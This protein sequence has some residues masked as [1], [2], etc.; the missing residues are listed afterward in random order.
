MVELALISV[1]ATQM[2]NKMQINQ[3]QERKRSQETMVIA[4]RNQ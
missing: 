1:H 2:K 4:R 3:Q